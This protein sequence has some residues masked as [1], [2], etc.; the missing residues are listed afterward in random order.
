MTPEEL[1]AVRRVVTEELDAVL[2]R[3]LTGRAK[4]RAGLLTLE[5]VAAVCHVS[6]ETV[7]HWIWE[8]RLTAYK[9]GRA[10]LVKEAELLA[11]V[12]ANETTKKRVER[13]KAAKS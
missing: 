10:P 7:R 3:H 9:P 12:E 8:G 6:P 1:E 4:P 2:A 5:E 11:F 13:R